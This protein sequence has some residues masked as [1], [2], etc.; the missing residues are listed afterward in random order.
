MCFFLSRVDVSIL[1]SETIRVVPIRVSGLDQRLER[2]S[3]SVVMIVW[4]HKHWKIV[5]NGDGIRSPRPEIEDRAATP[6]LVTRHDR[7]EVLYSIT[8]RS[9]RMLIQIGYS[10]SDRDLTILISPLYPNG[11][12][13]RLVHRQTSPNFVLVLWKHKT[14]TIE[15]MSDQKSIRPPLDRKKNTHHNLRSSQL[16]TRKFNHF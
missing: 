7:H 6:S 13:S 14:K 3:E 12:F 2:R 4:D 1:E 11:S 8:N 9:L 16:Y 15:G 5:T 10:V